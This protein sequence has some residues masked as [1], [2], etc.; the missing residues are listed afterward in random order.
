MPTQLISL[1]EIDL[2]IGGETLFDKATLAVQERARIALV[3]RNGSGKSTLM[4]IAAGLVE[5]DAGERFIHPGVT[6]RYLPQEPDASG[7][8]TLGEYVASGL[9]EMGDPHLGEAMLE[10][11]GL[12]PD[13]SPQGLSGGELRRAANVQALSAKPDILLLDEP[14]NHLDIPAIAWLENKLR[15]TAS[16][17]VLISHDRRFLQT[18]TTETVWIDR[19]ATRATGKGF[20]EF[21]SWRDKFLEEEEQALHKLGRKIVAEEHWMRYGVTARR[22]RNMR[23]VGELQA[24]RKQ[25]KETRRPQGAANISIQSGGASGK[26]AVV[27]EHISKSFGDCTIID[28][29]SIEIARGDRIGIVGP[30]GAGKTTLIN[31]L[32]GALTPGTG[33]VTLGTNLD[34]VSLDQRRASLKPE[35]R[36]ADAINDSTGDWVTINGHKRHVA[37]YLKD[38]LFEAEQWR[39]PVTALSGG[40]RGRLALAA[41][42]ARPSNLLILDEPTNDLDLE[43]LEMLEEQLAAYEGTLLLISHDRQFLDNLVTSVVTTDP[44]RSARWIRYA[45]GYD[46]MVAQRGSAP[47][48][49]NAAPKTK[50]LKQAVTGARPKSAAKAKLSYKEQYALKNLPGEIDTLQTQIAALKTKLEDPDLFAKDAALFD[51]AAK[52]LAAAE[53]SLAAKEEEWL[54]LEMRREEIE[55]A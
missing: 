24:M 15:Q 49:E 18:I 31:I 1:A 52:D 10:E 41:A 6:V 21:E 44:D 17:L 32:T 8:K 4:K 2:S 40:E 51:I 54:T 7:F 16:A 46:D 30:N 37:T 43:T 33:K 35:M 53:E 11:L 3:G 47:G 13:A 39:Q 55:S 26:R 9:D 12:T 42:M 34:I 23:R 19:G 25:L 45:G 14:T 28:D 29:F 5:P 20:R 38:F 22:K 27:A 36:V 50:P 48:M